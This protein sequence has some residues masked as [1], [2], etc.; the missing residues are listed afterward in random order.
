MWRMLFLLFVVIGAL[1]VL[2]AV[3][4][5]VGA[6]KVALVHSDDAP[7]ATG[8]VPAAS[9]NSAPATS[10]ASPLAPVPTTNPTASPAI[11]PA[12]PA[13]A[14]PAVPPL[15]APPL[16]APPVVAPPQAVVHPV[17]PA[18]GG[19]AVGGDA[20]AFVP[21][22]IV[23]RGAEAK[24]HGK[25]LRK[26]PP[27]GDL[28]SWTRLEEYATWV[29][30]PPRGKYRVVLT[31]ANGANSGGDFALA[32]GDS[33]K[34][35][36][37]FISRAVPTG[38]WDVFRS[39]FIGIL[40]LD[41]KRTT[42]CIRP[43]GDPASALMRLRKIELIPL[44]PPAFARPGEADA[45]GHPDISAITIV[46]A[47][48]GRPLGTLTNG[49]S[50]DISSLPP[51]SLRAETAGR[52]RSVRFTI[53]KA[54]QRVESERPFSIAGER[55]KGYI[56]WNPQPGKHTLQV[57]PFSE[58]GGAGIAGRRQLLFINIIS[59][60]PVVLR[61]ADA[62]LH[63]DSLRIVPGD[64]PTITGWNRSQDSIEWA[65]NVPTSGN[66]DVEIF[67]SVAKSN[68][69]TFSLRVGDAK[70][71]DD[72]SDTGGWDVF[73]RARVGVAKLSKGKT[74]LVIKPGDLGAGKT[75][76]NLREI[77]LSPVVEDD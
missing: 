6:A 15:V 16:A 75:L 63:G 13:V 43:S 17:A 5:G 53:D 68:G 55:G 40:D 50:L 2:M 76:M 49:M 52:V 14:A 1:A 22:T 56:P 46:E 3:I 33:R 7:V 69:G 23:L 29:F 20:P 25:L 47:A 67:Y 18:V 51:I 35:D 45:D 62:I 54:D 9:G 60:S 32:M 28:T 70:I 24:L 8:A 57:A 36:P 27:E 73:N 65:V 11:T 61:S 42:L 34:T 44:E 74:R 59:S 26:T 19:N 31:R 39:E 64:E 41:E 72:V 10:H 38:G 77:R 4:L 21:G 12:R 37:L 71:N 58:P 30:Y 66:Y 48:S